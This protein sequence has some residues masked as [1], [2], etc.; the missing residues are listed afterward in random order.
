MRLRA[1]HPGER[2][3]VADLDALDRLDP[4]ERGGEPR[5]E[6]VRLLGVRAEPGRDS[7]RPHL[8][9]PAEGVPVAARRVDRGADPVLA[10]G[11]AD[12]ERLAR[13]R[14][15]DRGEQR[16]GDGAGRDVNRGVARARALERVADVGE[17]VLQH[18]RRGRRARA[19]AA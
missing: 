10:A 13:D 6:P 4:G 16:L 9:D 5:V 12:L 1:A 2:E 17:P 14:D 8:D 18:P 19:A 15:P 11:A 3:A 7:G